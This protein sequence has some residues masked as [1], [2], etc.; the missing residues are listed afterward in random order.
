MPYPNHGDAARGTV[1]AWAIRARAA[2]WRSRNVRDAALTLAVLAGLTLLGDGLVGVL[3]LPVPGPLVGSAI[4]VAWLVWRPA[5]TETL[6]PA[7]GLIAALP[8]LFLPLL[9]EAVGPLRALGPALLPVVVT[10][11][12]ATLAALVA[13]VA[14]AR[15]AAWLCSR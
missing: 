12:V 4:L 7:D 1:R 8:L 2:S 14:A 11:T 15:I 13:A 9:V 6:K 10:M 3:R 5:Q